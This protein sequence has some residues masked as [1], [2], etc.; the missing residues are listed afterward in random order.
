MAGVSIYQKEMMR[1]EAHLIS[2]FKWKMKEENALETEDRLEMEENTKRINGT[3][4]KEKRASRAS[5]IPNFTEEEG[6][7]V[8]SDHQIR[9]QSQT[10][11]TLRL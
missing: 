3:K 7:R 2:T 4:T 10:T 11:P 8:G 5:V 1:S 9:A 6:P